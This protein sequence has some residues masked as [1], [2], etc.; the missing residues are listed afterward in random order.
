M[1]ELKK[2]ISTNEPYGILGKKKQLRILNSLRKPEFDNILILCSSSGHFI[3]I[4]VL[5]IIYT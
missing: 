4:Q 5:I 2:L 3:G 1:Y